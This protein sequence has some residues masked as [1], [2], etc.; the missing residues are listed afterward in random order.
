MKD[1]TL[2]K[3]ADL[4]RMIAFFARAEYIEE[5]KSLEEDSPYYL[6]FTLGSRMVFTF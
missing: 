6:P 3:A 4:N 2:N 1:K 5:G